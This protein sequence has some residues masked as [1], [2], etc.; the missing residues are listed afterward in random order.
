ME[1]MK[2]KTSAKD[3][4]QK[5]GTLMALAILFLIFCAVLPTKFPKVGNL[6]NIL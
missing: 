2:K 4:M 5:L 6:M 3:L 1:T